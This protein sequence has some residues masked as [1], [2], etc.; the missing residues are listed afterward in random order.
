MMAATAKKI[1]KLLQM[2][3]HGVGETLFENLVAVQSLMHAL[4]LAHHEAP[5]VPQ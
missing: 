2:Q 1:H 4:A 3:P 5:T